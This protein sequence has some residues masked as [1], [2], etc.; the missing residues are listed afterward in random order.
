LWKLPSSVITKLRSV[1]TNKLLPYQLEGPA[2]VGLF[3]YDHNRFVIETFA[4]I[5]QKWQI[6]LA[7]GKKLQPMSAK[8]KSTLMSHTADGSTLHE[9]KL[10]PSS[11][12]AFQVVDDGQE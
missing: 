2:H 9:I 4:A 3:T 11:F 10:A 12:S 5:P 1:F 6:R 7:A 8:A